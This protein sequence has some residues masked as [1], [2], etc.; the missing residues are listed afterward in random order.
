MNSDHILP[1]VSKYDRAT[2][3]QRVDEI[4]DWPLSSNIV[5]SAYVV[6]SCP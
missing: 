5:T 6:K 1:Q 2:S 4:L 3:P